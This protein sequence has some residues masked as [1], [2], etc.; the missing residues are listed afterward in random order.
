MG[1]WS[2]LNPLTVLFAI[3]ISR[4]GRHIYKVSHQS[5]S[6]WWACLKILPKTL[7]RKGEKFEQ[8]VFLVKFIRSHISFP[9]LEWLHPLFIYW[10]IYFIWF[11]GMNCCTRNLNFSLLIR[12]V[13]SPCR[14]GTHNKLVPDRLR[15][16]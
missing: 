4:I 3:S 8:F 11:T 16:R 2:G 10:F 5:V 6:Q 9:L 7:D 12:L 14:L 15:G 1:W 13:T